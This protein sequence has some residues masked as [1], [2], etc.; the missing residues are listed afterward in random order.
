MENGVANLDGSGI[1]DIVEFCNGRVTV[2]KGSKDEKKE[3]NTD[4]GA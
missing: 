2:R 3:R 1:I 4:G